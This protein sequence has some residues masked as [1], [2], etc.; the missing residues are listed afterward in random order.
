MGKTAWHL[1]AEEGNQEA[2]QKLWECGK[3]TLTA[4]EL[5]N[6]LLLFKENMEKNAWHLAA[7]EG[8]HEALQNFGNVVMKT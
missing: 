5:S 3:E 7:E 2:L 4:D 8:N 1:A 6:K